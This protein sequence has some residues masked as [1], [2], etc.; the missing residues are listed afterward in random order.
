MALAGLTGRFRGQREKT[1]LLRN[2]ALAMTTD[3]PCSVI[4]LGAEVVIVQ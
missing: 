3:C 2:W 1:I 4:I